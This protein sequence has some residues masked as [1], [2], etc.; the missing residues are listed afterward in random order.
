LQGFSPLG[1]PLKRAEILACVDNANP[2]TGIPLLVRMDVGQYGRVLVFG[3]SDTWRW[4]LPSTLE[5]DRQATLNLHARFWKQMVLWLAHQDEIEGNVYVR[6]EFRRLVANGRQTIRMG[7]RD[8]RGDEV[9]ES[10]LRY[11]IVGPDEPVDRTKAKRADRDPKGGGRASFETKAPGE[12]RVVA[13]G[14]G[15]DASGEKITGDA[16]ARYVVYPDISDEMLRPAA[17]PEF[18]LALE[19][20]ANGTAL[21]SARRADRLPAFLEEMKINPPKMSTPK[22]KPYPDWRR[23]KQKWFLPAVLILFVAVLGL[24]WGLRRAWGMV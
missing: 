24:E 18:L 12:Y 11:Q 20:T 16:I 1:D 13:W 7:V 17:N 6:P 14:E 19:N 3:A 22:P 15:T 4:T 9:P 23:D 8:K 2:M 10:D 21:D 5:N